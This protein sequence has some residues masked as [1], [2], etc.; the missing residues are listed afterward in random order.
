M[1]EILY[2][3]QEIVDKFSIDLCDI[4]ASSRNTKEFE[5]HKLYTKEMETIISEHIKTAENPKENMISSCKWTKME[6]NAQINNKQRLILAI[7][8]EEFIHNVLHWIDNNVVKMVPILVFNSDNNKE[9]YYE[10]E[11]LQIITLTMTVNV[12]VD[13]GISYNKKVEIT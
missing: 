11:Y 3:K 5:T 13:I 1:E 12:R 10:I 4:P 8:K 9:W 6:V 2:T 7:N